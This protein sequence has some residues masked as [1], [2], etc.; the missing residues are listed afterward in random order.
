MKAVLSAEPSGI[1]LIDKHDD[2][3]SNDVCQFVKHYFKLKKVGHGG[4]LDP[5]ATGLLV[6]YLNK[7]T[8]LA[9]QSISDSKVYEGVIRFG[10]KTSTGDPLGE[11]IQEKEVS[12]VS[13][14]TVTDVFNQFVG[15]L[16][17][18]PPMVSAIKKDGVPLYKLA[19]KGIV[20][21]REKRKIQIFSLELMKNTFPFVRFR[22]HVSKGTYIRTLAED[23]GEKINIPA[24]LSELRRISSG[25]F[26]IEQAITTDQIKQMD[27]LEDVLPHLIDIPK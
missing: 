6:L 19:R 1:L 8:K 11:I 26:N 4:T 18:T 12:L 13:D 27:S 16:W 23:I 25:D 7:A 24:S 2:W 22:A 10:V 5:F 17:Q 21:E 9:S 20:V 14:Q 15:E 3:T